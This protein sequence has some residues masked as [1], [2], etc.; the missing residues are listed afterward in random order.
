MFKNNFKIG[1]FDFN[2]SLGS[3]ITISTKRMKQ[4]VSSSFGS[5]AIISYKK[6]VLE[7]I[8]TIY[9]SKTDD[10]VMTFF[11]YSKDF[12]FFKNYLLNKIRKS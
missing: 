1:L 4:R 12:K 7:H 8:K 3:M 2:A 6:S 9:R 11:D 10:L 5:Y